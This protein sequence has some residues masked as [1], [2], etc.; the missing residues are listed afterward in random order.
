MGRYLDQLH[1]EFNELNDGIT[2]IVDRAADESRDVTDDENTQVE[3][4][5]A[6]AAELET[7]IKHYTD[8]E[9][10]TDRVAAMRGRVNNGPRTLNG[11]PP[12]EPEY[13][14][15]REFPTIG[16]YAITV[17]RAMM[18]KDSDAIAKLERATAHQVTGDN[19][20]LIPRPILGPV[21]N[22]LDSTRPFINSITTRPLPTGKF[23]RPVITQHV[24]VA[25]QAQEKDLTASQKMIVG[26]IAVAAKTWA[27]HL[28]IS[29]QDVKWTSPAILQLVYEDFAAM[30]AAATCDYASDQFVASVTAA[31]IAIAEATG[32]A[33]T[34]A[35]YEGSAAALGAQAP[36][37]DTLWVAPDV[38]AGLG[39]MV[40]ANSGVPA[41]PGMSVTGT[42]GNPLGLKLVVDNHFAAGTMIAGP[43]R[44]AEWY[45]DV[46]GLLQVGEPDVLGQL[47]GYAGFGAFI[48]VAPAAFSK[49]TMAAPVGGASATTAS[50]SS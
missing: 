12:A 42:G 2:A 43:S 6:R 27:G 20:G 14:V 24:A 7:A 19:P 41:F 23:D 35:L 26:A 46:D 11:G 13:D 30:Y 10:R 8:I 18:L 45:E 5:Q 47:V 4:D 9:Q 40:N 1:A 39:G 36:L 32:A 21:I 28:N 49:Y 16:D 3:R 15:E 37:P 44:Y 50:K 31:P 33:V 22:L 29:R 34:A 25:E 38:W 17:H 48:N